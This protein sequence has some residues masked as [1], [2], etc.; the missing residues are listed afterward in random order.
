MEPL[1]P[2]IKIIEPDGRW[3][4]FK[5]DLPNLYQ[6]AEAMTLNKNVPE[7]VRVQFQQAQHLLV[8]SYLQYSLLSVAMTQALIAVEF[9]LRTRWENDTHGQIRKHKSLPGFK[10]LLDHAIEQNWVTDFDEKIAVYFQTLRNSL[11]HGNYSLSPIDILE[12][13]GVCGKFIQQLYS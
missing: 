4:V 10:H 5:I 13:V 1:K 11:A 7:Y 9:A 3:D 2:L 8:Y 12:D 6:R